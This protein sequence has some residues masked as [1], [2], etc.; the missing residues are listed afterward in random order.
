MPRGER[1]R[2]WPT[3]KRDAFA[4]DWNTGMTADA[5]KEKYA[6]RSPSAAAA[7][8][9]RMGYVIATRYATARRERAAS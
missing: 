3:W 6:V 8:L 4:R 2:Q 5:L 1:H 9:K 7:G